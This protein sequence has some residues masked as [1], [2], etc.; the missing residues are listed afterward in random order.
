M[1]VKAVIRII[2]KAVK[3]KNN[4][5]ISEKL[6]INIPIFNIMPTLIKNK[7]NKIFLNE[8]MSDSTW[9]LYRVSEIIMPARNAPRA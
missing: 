4:K 8:V 7:P 3:V 5:K 2:L 9:C 1:V 6:S